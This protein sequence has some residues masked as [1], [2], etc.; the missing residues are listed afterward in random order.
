MK[1]LT[2]QELLEAPPK[3]QLLY[4]KAVVKQPVGSKIVE[5]AI[6][7]HPE[8]FPD[9]IEHRIKYSLIP[10]QVH[11]DYWKERDVLIA[12]IYKEMPP[13]KGILGWFDDLKG[14][15]E[16]NEAYKKCRKAEELLAT[17]LHNKFYGQYG[18][19]EKRMVY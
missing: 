11:D 5:D 13:S 12:E 18:I 8:Y 15:Q 7:E 3:V 17:T 19:N 1:V 16:W 10:Q 14:F 6:T 9:E 2:Y 4:L